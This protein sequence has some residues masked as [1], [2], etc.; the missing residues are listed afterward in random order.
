[1]KSFL[2]ALGSGGKLG[3]CWYLCADTYLALLLIRKWLSRLESALNPLFYLSGSISMTQLDMI[4][5]AHAGLPIVKQWIEEIL[6]SLNPSRPELQTRFVT[7]FLKATNIGFQ[8]D[9]RFVHDC[10]RRIPVVHH[11]YDEESQMARWPMLQIHPGLLRAGPGDTPFYVLRELLDFLGKGS[12]VN[13]KHGI[14]FL[15][16]VAALSS[17]CVR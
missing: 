14:L 16:Y 1:M 5:E 17:G 8:F 2:S 12:G 9:E 10:L 11:A 4:P 7:N 13:L 6:F 15:E 3:Y